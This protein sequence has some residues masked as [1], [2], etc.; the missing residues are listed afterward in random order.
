MGVASSR[1]GNSIDSSRGMGK[2]GGDAH[3][4]PPSQGLGLGSS[5]IRRNSIDPGP[6]MG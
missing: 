4:H 1:D 3:P 2:Q 6:V 5:R